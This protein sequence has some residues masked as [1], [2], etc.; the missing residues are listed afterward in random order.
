MVKAE[1]HSIQYILIKPVHLFCTVIAI[2]EALPK[3]QSG[4]F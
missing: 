3:R 1:V 2:S 4:T